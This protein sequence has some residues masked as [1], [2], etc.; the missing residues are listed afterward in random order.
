M[1][2]RFILLFLA[3]FVLGSLAG[4]VFIAGVR[5]SKASIFDS[6]LDLFKSGA[7]AA[8][9]P[10]LGTAE[11]PQENKIPLYKPIF[12]YEE[13]VVKA[14]EKASPSVVSIVI[15]K[16]LPI[17]ENCPYD[18]FGDLPPEFRDFFGDSFGG[19][20]FERPCERG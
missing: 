14:V 2:R 11:T 3:V 17:I 20:R 16:D 18:P 8:L 6:F 10:S 4:G 13:A 9:A 1:K 12:D 7:P 5:H 15:S 19:P